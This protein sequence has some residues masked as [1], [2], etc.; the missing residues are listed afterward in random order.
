[1]KSEYFDI[2]GLFD[3]K[4]GKTTN[5]QEYPTGTVPYVSAT[6]KNN[7]VSFFI[8]K[9]P[10]FE[11]NVLTVSRNGSVG[12]VFYQS[13]PFC[14]SLDDIRI[15]VPKFELNKNIA[16]YLSALL[17]KEKFRYTYGRKF[18]TD[19]IKK[20][21]IR[22]PVNE[23]NNPDWAYISSTM[24]ATIDNLP[25]NVKNVLNNNFDLSPEIS[26][27]IILN[28]QTWR[29]FLFSEIFDIINGYY[30]KKPDK[31]E[32]GKIPFIGATES[33]NGITDHYSLFD[34]ENNNK[35]ERSSEH[36]ISQKIF[37]GNC[38]TISNNG[39]VGYAFYQNKDFT[40]SH[41]VNVLYLKDREWN[42]HIALFICTLISLERYR[43]A[44]GR[45]WR[46]SRMP[47]SVL[48]LPVDNDGK[49]DWV[50]MEKY[51]KSLPYSGSI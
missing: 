14:A 31:T 33:N 13:K 8:K 29:K 45:K 32:E 3:V 23:Y 11:G 1:M 37:K 28:T 16:L 44:Y 42:K 10:D 38:I 5:P 12:E 35:D 19:R 6:E 4:S 22:L 21:K 40:C 46:P 18:G 41:D 27:K 15:L 39:S 17:R 26:Q 24:E 25:K 34:I 50:F 48:K 47:A 30:N 7:G 20:T 49:P 51:I 9:E 36:L 43:W 2:E